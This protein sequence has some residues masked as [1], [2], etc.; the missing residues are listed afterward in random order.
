MI[1]IIKRI[2]IAHRWRLS[3]EMISTAIVFKDSL[4]VFDCNLNLF[5]IP[6]SSLS[7][8]KKIEISDR[9]KF[10]IPEDGSYVHWEKYDIHLDLEAFKS[11]SK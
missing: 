11:V 4:I 3:N 5:R 9:L 8:L 6:F 2:I 7:A 10:A 1:S